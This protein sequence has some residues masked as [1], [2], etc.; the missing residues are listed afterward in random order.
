M[1]NAGVK[2]YEAAEEILKI[3]HQTENAIRSKIVSPEG[4]IKI[5]TYD[6]IARYFFPGFLKFMK[7]AA[8]ELD[9][10]LETSRSSDIF[11]RV[12][13][14]RLEIGV[15]IDSEKYKAKNVTKTVLY[16]DSFGLYTRPGGSKEFNDKLISFPASTYDEEIIKKLCK[17][18][19]FTSSIKC[20]NLETV[21]S[22][23][24]EGLGIG[25]MPHLVARDSL[26]QGKLSEVKVKKQ[27]T[28]LF[29]HSII[30]I[31]RNDLADLS[32]KKTIEDLA[33]FLNAWAVK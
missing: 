27:K 22:F 10:S 7:S 31:Q 1:T 28:P 8:P 20:D 21:K 33:R 11:K 18:N 4:S 2:L 5:G 9:I 19:N 29:E 17:N 15:I 32:A 30:L 6:S 3:S 12:K 23:A 16:S 24:E 13:D 14:N 25:L 26:L